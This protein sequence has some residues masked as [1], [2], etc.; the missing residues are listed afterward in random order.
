MSSG[1]IAGIIKVY[2]FCREGAGGIGYGDSVGSVYADCVDYEVRRR[3]IGEGD[4]WR[5]GRLDCIL[6]YMICF[7]DELGIGLDVSELSWGWVLVY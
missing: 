4:R 6:L 7:G 5:V 3:E 1:E 2:F